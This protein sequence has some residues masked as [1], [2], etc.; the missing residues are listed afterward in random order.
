MR[1]R[2]GRWRYLAVLCA[3]FVSV[4]C[5]R[6]MIKGAVVNAEGEQ[7][8]GV[9]VNLVGSDYSDLTNV[10]GE[11]EIRFRPGDVILEFAKTGYTPARLEMTVE[12]GA[13]VHP[14]VV[15]MWRLPIFSG[16][17]LL[18]NFRYHE[19][20]GLEL[21]T[22]YTENDD[23][24]LGTQRD[25]SLT[26]ERT[27][28]LIV[29]FGLPRYDARLHR[30]K[31]IEARVATGEN[32]LQPIWVAAESLPVDVS[33]IDQPEG[34][35]LQLQLDAPLDPGEYAVHWGAFEGYTTLDARIFPFRVV[36]VAAEA[37][38]ALADAEDALDD[39][40]EDAPS[41]E[42]AEPVEE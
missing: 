29:T 26:T 32:V 1:H 33:P 20:P 27:E 2:R 4:S 9:A 31:Q 23:P 5:N 17:Y 22:F 6:P 37:D 28:P 12:S 38:Q 25:I 21:K 7:L 40:A 39:E 30:L 34:V 42:E 36:D 13:V 8:P 41:D 18:D 11:Y 3:L 19:A 16:V 35:L 14:P 15:E 10:L 24:I